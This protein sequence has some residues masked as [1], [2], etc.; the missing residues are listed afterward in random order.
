MEFLRE[1]K[2][3]KNFGHIYRTKKA[4]K[5]L[6]VMFCVYVLITLLLLLP[7]ATS[8]LQR[9]D[10]VLSYD[11]DNPFILFDERALLSAHRAGGALA[12]ENTMSAFINCL[13]SVEYNVDILEFDLR[14]TKDN[15]LVLLHDETLDRT[16]NSAE[17]FGKEKVKA[18]EKTL[19]ELK[20]LNM[21]ENFLAENG[22]MPYR[23]LRGNDIPEQVKIPAFEEVLAYCEAKRSDLRYIVEIKD[24]GSLGKRAADKVY[25]ILS[26]KGLT[27]K[28]IIGSFKSEVLKYLDEKYPSLARSASPAEALLTYYRFLFNVNLNK[29]GVKF[30]V[31]QIPNLKFFKTGGVAFI[32]YCHHYDIAVQYWT[33]NDKDEMRSLIKSRADA[34]IT[35]N[36]ALAYEV[37][38]GK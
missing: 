23:G 28:V 19:T 12:P 10:P 27:D 6:G 15:E 2:I 24:G 33:I 20:Q 8:S 9:V 7:V 4:F 26:Q 35:D 36:P 1:S 32:D 17:F 13:E 3:R 30:E 22:T 18:S 14:L 5:I 38:K 16:S 29:Y 34:I 31:L 25:E 37:L 11:G 21:G